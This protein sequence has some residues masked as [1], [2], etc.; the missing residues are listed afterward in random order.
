MKS[1]MFVV[2]T[3][4]IFLFL[5]LLNTFLLA[6]EKNAQL[7]KLAPKDLWWI[8]GGAG[9]GRNNNRLKNSNTTGWSGLYGFSYNTNKGLV[10]L[11]YLG[12][13]HDGEIP[14]YVNDLGIL[15]GILGMQ[16]SQAVSLSIGI[17]RIYGYYKL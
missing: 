10:S 1:R 11:R 7:M 13:Y 17:S 2:K 5:M 3:I 15:Y 9:Y 14:N 4:S 6:E 8:Y 12:A 16:N